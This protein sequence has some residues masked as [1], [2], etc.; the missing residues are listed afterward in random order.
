MRGPGQTNVKF[1]TTR[2]PAN[3]PQIGA[4][5]CKAKLLRLFDQI[6]LLDALEK[7]RYHV[8]VN[9]LYQIQFGMLAVKY[10]KNT[11]QLRSRPSYISGFP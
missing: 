9:P 2:L 1:T 8:V 10:S 11:R 6:A 7:Y 3:M 4:V 5:Q